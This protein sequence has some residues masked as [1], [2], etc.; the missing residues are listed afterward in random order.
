MR[1][2]L[3]YDVPLVAVVLLLVGFGLVMAFSASAVVSADRYGTASTILGRQATAAVLG[4]VAFLAAAR[5]DYTVYA[6]RSVV[7]TLVAVTAGALVLPHVLPGS[8]VP[9]W[10]RLGPVQFPAVGAR[11][12]HR[13]P[14]HGSTSG[15]P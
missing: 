5:T 3:P 12:A 11:Q 6:E 14:L 15:P 10:I 13:D 9:R 4:F 7:W 1:R 8:G 2:R